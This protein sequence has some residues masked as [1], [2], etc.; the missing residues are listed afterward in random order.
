MTL[1]VILEEKARGSWWASE[2]AEA[3][4]CGVGEE[5]AGSG[6]AWY[7]RDSLMGRVLAVEVMSRTLA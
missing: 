5:W 2:E 6:C 7:S 3:R 1:S 4:G